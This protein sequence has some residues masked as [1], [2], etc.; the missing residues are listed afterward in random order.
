MKIF[1]FSLYIAL[2]LNINKAIGSESGM[3]QLNPEFWAAQT[4]WLSLI[5]IFLYMMIWKIFLP[6]I[7]NNI[8]NRKMKVLN[9]INDA[10]KLKNSAEKKFQEYKKIIENAKKEAKKIILE[11][12]KKLDKNIESKKQKFDEE[13]E[14]ELK[15]VEKEIINLKE[16]SKSSVNKI[17]IEIASEIVTKITGATVNASNVS[18]IVEDVAKRKMESYL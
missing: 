6:K 7:T 8:E 1:Y 16:T 9:D 14:K 12:K 4:F 11:N 3:P 10:Q 2:A 13:I 15:N 18:A 17:A 5:F